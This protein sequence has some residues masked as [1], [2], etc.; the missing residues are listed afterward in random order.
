[1]RVFRLKEKE[2]DLPKGYRIGIRAL[3]MNARNNR[4]S[5]HPNTSVDYTIIDI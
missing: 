1:V 5:N 2:M 4:D 3:S